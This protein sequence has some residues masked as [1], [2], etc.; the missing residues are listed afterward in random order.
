MTLQPPCYHCGEPVLT[1]DRYSLQREDEMLPMCCPACLAVASTIFDGGLGRYYRYRDQPGSRP[2]TTTDFSA[3]DQPDFLSQILRHHADDSAEVSLLIGGMHCAACVWLLEHQLQRLPGVSRA[4]VSLDQQRALVRFVPDQVPLSRLC[5]TMADIGYLPQPD[6]P[7][8]AERLYRAEQR[9]A[10]RRLGV[11]GIGMMQVGM[12]ALALHVG[13]LQGISDELRQFLRW[14]SALV[15]T[16][17]VLYAAQPFFLAAWRGI[18][19]LRPGMDL[20][21]ALAIG[22]A[23]LASLWATW[24]D[25]GEVYFDSV[26][27]FTFFLLAGRYLEM[28]ARHYSGRRVSDLQSLLPTTTLRLE[29]AEN[30]QPTTVH[31]SSLQIGD[32]VL[33]QPGQTVP[34]DGTVVNGTPELNSAI[35]T[36]EFAPRRHSPGQSVSAGAVN[37]DQPFTLQV[38][39]VGADLRIHAVQRLMQQAAASRAPQTLLADRIARGFVMAVLILAA[40]VFTLWWQ[41]APERAFWVTLSVLVVSCPC[42]LSLA[43][44]V[45][46]TAAT[47][48]LRHH[49]LLVTRAEVWEQ[50][51]AVTDVV[52]DKTGTLTRGLLSLRQCRPLAHLTETQCLDVAAG[53]ETGSNHPIA[54]AFGVSNLTVEGIRHHVGNGVSGSINGIDYRLGRADWAWP[55]TALSPP[56]DSGQWLLLADLQQPLA[57][58]ELDDQLRPEATEAITGLRNQGLCLHLLSGDPSPSAR[59]LGESLALDHI[60]TG[61]SPEQKLAYVRN[62]QQE[63]R[64]VLMVGDGVNDLPVLAQADIGVAMQEAPDLAKTRADAVLLAADLKLLPQLLN[65]SGLCRRVIRQNLVWALGYNSLALPIAAAGWVPPWLAAIGMSAS[66]LCV[67]LNAL[68][69]QRDTGRS[70]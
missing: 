37:G 66:S 7:D 6:T 15:A 55:A 24:Q 46:L 58:F 1:G 50:A 14:I 30:R 42:A 57:W 67:V 10:L 44:P 13:A 3:Y 4:R 65:R 69:L 40:L 20:P 28:R 41:W 34:A 38:S 43:T 59:T 16:P 48:A 5:Q 32:R 27:M 62:L 8:N 18:R 17:V 56:A 9:S 49:G 64:R 36:G 68:R 51:S 29:G 52:F 47:N 60:C 12:Y 45:A 19:Q 39:A 63:G 22:L 31:L 61:A 35:L 23:Y 26:S 53:L 11:A 54:W 70:L 25:H 21:V 2:E 33:V